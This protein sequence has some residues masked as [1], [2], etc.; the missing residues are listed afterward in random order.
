MSR[1]RLLPKALS[2]VHP[3]HMTPHIITIMTGVAVALGTF[4][5]DINEAAE[6]CNIGT[7]SAFFIVCLGVII[8]RIAEPERERS[9][10]VP[11]MPLSLTFT[12][13]GALFAI[14]LSKIFPV[15]VSH[16]VMALASI[17]AVSGLLLRGLKNSVLEK[18]SELAIPFYGMLTCFSLILLGV[19]HRTFIT[20]SVWLTLGII[21]YFSYSY[22]KSQRAKKQAQ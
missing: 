10:R 8:L 21:F 4:L 7:L 9:F 1:D 5:L 3:E 17:G 11:S 22:I 16:L 20:F 13:A 19:P 6:L 15:Q 2:R 14:V 12:I 18:V